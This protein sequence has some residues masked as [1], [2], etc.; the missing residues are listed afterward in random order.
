MWM[1]LPS[2][3]KDRECIIP[4]VSR[5][6]HFGSQGLHMN[7]FFQELYFKKHTLN[8]LPH[9][10]LKDVDRCVSVGHI[11]KLNSWNIRV[12]LFCHAVNGTL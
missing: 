5:T 12:L 8:T 2:V 6:Y 11:Y 7:T 3:R 4:D 10:K 9:V 1:R